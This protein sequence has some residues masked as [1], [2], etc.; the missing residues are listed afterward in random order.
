MEEAPL[1]E[2]EAVLF[3]LFPDFPRF[4]VQDA[5]EMADKSQGKRD[6]REIISRLVPMVARAYYDPRHVVVLDLLNSAP[7]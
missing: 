2:G 6:P 1:Y 7:M 3:C 4:A 5:E